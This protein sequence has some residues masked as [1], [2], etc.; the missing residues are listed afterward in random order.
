MKKEKIESSVNSEKTINSENNGIKKVTEKSK[1][2]EE[3]LEKVNRINEKSL[4]DKTTANRT[5]WKNEVLKN[6]KTEKTARRLLRNKQ[7][8][9]SKQVIKFFKISDANNLKIASENLEKFYS[10]NIVNRNKFTNISNEKD[11]GQII[12]FASEISLN[13]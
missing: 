6:F 2:F 5:I 13:L 4:S 7:T 11:K 8:E 1:T 10:D 12:Q 9:L 3:L